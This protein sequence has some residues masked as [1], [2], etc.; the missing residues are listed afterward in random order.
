VGLDR[1]QP[2]AW[3]V[4]AAAGEGLAEAIREW[5]DGTVLDV[6]PG[7]A[8]EERD[9]DGLSRHQLTNGAEEHLAKEFGRGR[10]ET[11]VESLRGERHARR[12]EPCGEGINGGVWVVDPTEHESLDERRAGELATSANEADT[13]GNAIGVGGQ[14]GLEGTGESGNRGR[15]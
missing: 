10:S 2:G 1:G 6:H 3:G 4:S 11:L 15:H 8:L 9:G 14:D 13:F 5:D 12:S 7:E